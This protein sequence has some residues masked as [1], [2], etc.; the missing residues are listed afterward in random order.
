M[1]NILQAQKGVGNDPKTSAVATTSQIGGVSYEQVQMQSTATQN[2]P[3][4]AL[5]RKS[6]NRD[7][8]KRELMKITME[9]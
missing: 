2:N 6:L 1:T 8:R 9:N 7:A 4:S 5:Q 3:L